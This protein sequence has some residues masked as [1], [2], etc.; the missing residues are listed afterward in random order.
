[1]YARKSFI[2]LNIIRFQNK[3]EVLTFVRDNALLLPS[4]YRFAVSDVLVLVIK[5]LLYFQAHSKQQ[6]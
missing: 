1:M 4:E 2:C 6:F 5:G 3:Q